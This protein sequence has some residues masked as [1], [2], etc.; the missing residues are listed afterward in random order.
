MVTGTVALLAKLPVQVK[1]V[2]TAP[3]TDQAIL[4]DVSGLLPWLESSTSILLVL[5]VNGVD[6]VIKLIIPASLLQN[7]NSLAPMVVGLVL[8]VPLMSKGAEANSV[9]SCNIAWLMVKLVSETKKGFKLR[10]LASLPRTVPRA[11]TLE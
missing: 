4:T 9:P 5:L 7:T 10:E 11:L 8:V 6:G 2:C 1:G 3:F